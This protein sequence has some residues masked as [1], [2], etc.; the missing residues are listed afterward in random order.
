MEINILL[1][2][3]KSCK[4]R[5]VYIENKGLYYSIYDYLNIFYEKPLRDNC[6]R[7]VFISIKHLFTDFISHSLTGTGSGL[8]LSTPMTHI[9]GLR[10]MLSLLPDKKRKNH[11]EIVNIF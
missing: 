11:V 2:N 9:D 1:S 8:N 3:D 4:M 6:G 5:S 7:C 10:E